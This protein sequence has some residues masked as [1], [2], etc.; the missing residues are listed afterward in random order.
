MYAENKAEKKHEGEPENSRRR[1]VIT[2]GSAPSGVSAEK[3]NSPRARRRD[4]LKIIF[5]GS[6]D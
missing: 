6:G 3:E 5:F 2:E 1:D 4:S